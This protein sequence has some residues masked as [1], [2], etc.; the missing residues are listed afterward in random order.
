MKILFIADGRSPIARNWIRYFAGRGDEVILA[1][2][3]QCEV[4]FPLKRL[5]FTPVA[6]S[7][8]KKN[9]PFPR[10][11]SARMLRLG[12]AQALGL[13]TAIR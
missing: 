2:T 12:S 10:S 3:F 4:D 13:R 5:E 8:F 6:F 7:A 1:S 9:S 11:A